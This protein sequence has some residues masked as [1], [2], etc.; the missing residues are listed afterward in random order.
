MAKTQLHSLEQ[1]LLK[2]LNVYAKSKNIVVALSG[3]LDSKALL[4]AANSLKQQ[5]MIQSLSAYHIDH[6]I[7]KNSSQ[8]LKTCQNDCENLGITFYSTQLNLFKNQQGLSTQVVPENNARKQRYNF[9]SSQLTNDDCLL[10]AHHQDDQ[11]ETLL[12]RLLRGTGIN[13]AMAMPVHRQLGKGILLRPWLNA[14][15]Q[16]IEQY[17]NEKDL[18]WIDDPSNDENTYDRNFLRNE[19]FPLLK[20]RWKNVNHAFARFS[21]LAKEHSDLAQEVAKQDL[22]F[23]KTEQNIV[24]K[25]FNQLSLVRR[26]NLLHFYTQSFFKQPASSNEIDEAINQL[27]SEKEQSIK[28]KVS[29]GWLRSYAGKIYLLEKSQPSNHFDTCEWNDLGKPITL[30]NNLVLY[31]TKE[32]SDFKLR[33]PLDNEK[34]TVRMRKGGEKICPHYRDKSNSLKKVYQECNVP[35]WQRDWLPLIYFNHELVAVPNVFIN[36]AFVAKSSEQ[37]LQLKV[38]PNPNRKK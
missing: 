12:F 20:S 28:V 15:K 37:G 21:R 18:C 26:K 31:A 25:N 22:D 16:S 33:L 38:N 1:L 7:N 19:I 3:G 35:V 34:V 29:N 17:A 4:I 9:F 23:C 2:Q 6:G 11:A 32:K 14:S 13:G 10:F 5:G 27:Q 8:W 30:S 36:K 24:I